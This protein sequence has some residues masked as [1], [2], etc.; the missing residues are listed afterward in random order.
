MRCKRA[1]RRSR[2]NYL[3]VDN[4]LHGGLLP[5]H[6]SAGRSQYYVGAGSRILPEILGRRADTRH[7]HEG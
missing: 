4:I 5:L 6:G 1:F 2:Q 3:V 7:N